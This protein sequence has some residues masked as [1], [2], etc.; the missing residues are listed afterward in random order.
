M[1]KLLNN[2]DR[3]IVMEYLKRNHIETTFIIGNVLN[4][5]LENDKNI[6][7]CAD[8]YGYFEDTKLKGILPFY[9]LG[10]CI[11][12]YESM[13]AVP[14]FAEIMKERKFNYLLGM[15][16]IVRPLY[17]A[18]KEYKELENFSEEAYYKNDNFKPFTLDGIEIIDGKLLP[19]DDVEIFI[20]EAYKDV[21]R[22]VKT[23][24]EIE[25]MFRERS[26]D[27]DF[28]FLLRDGK[29]KAQA[30]IQTYTSKINQVGGVFT[31]RDERGKGYCKAIVSE[32]C[33][34]IIQRGKTPTLM[35]RKNNTP[36]VRAYEALGFRYYCDYLLIS[37]K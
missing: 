8:Y 15:E 30:N 14:T 20:K 33:R 9:N 17:E 26:I 7:R 1:L 34:R 28:L 13:D 6:R 10:S 16:H 5:G 36:A 29:I 24:D 35:V 2:T 32:L 3:E 27:E 31:L 37:Y 22:S 19:L 12:H 4:F 11:P 25:K 21:F 23:K 18:I